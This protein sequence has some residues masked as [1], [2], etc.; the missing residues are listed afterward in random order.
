PWA[1]ARRLRSLDFDWALI[2][3][4]SPRSALEAWLAGIPTRIG[5]GRGLRRWL[6]TVSVPPRPDQVLMRKRSVGEVRR[7]TERAATAPL[8]RYSPGAH[9]IYQ[10]LHLTAALGANAAPLPPRLWL[11]KQEIVAAAEKFGLTG[12]VLGLNAGAEYGP[13]KRWPADRFVAAALAVQQQAPQVRWLILGGPGDTAL[14]GAITG[15][16][17]R[18]LE[19][20]F[21]G[22]AEGR[23][24]VNVAGRTSLRELLALLAGCRAVLTNDTGPMHLAAAV[25]TP[26][27]VPFGSTSPGL[28]GPGLP[29]DTSHQLLQGQAACAPCFLRVCPID[30]RC[31]ESISVAAV[32]AAVLRVMDGSQ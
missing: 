16:L 8:P 31:M 21:P 15:K 30:F 22:L 19:N 26:V 11:D 7:L 25:G 32:S 24:P 6:L 13:A 27:V 28:T 20:A 9:H 29:G 14:A 2:L 3:P 1:I 5:Y 4:N 23:R 17:N 10:Y 12:L 18:A